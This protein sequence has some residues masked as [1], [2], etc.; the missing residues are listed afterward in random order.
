MPIAQ[1]TDTFITVA[2]SATT[3]IHSLAELVDRAR[4]QP[5]KLNYNAGAGALPYVFAGFL[6]KLDLSMILVSYRD[7]ALPVQDLGEGR[8][9]IMMAPITMMQA[10]ANAGKVRLIALTN[11]R[12]SPTADMTPTAREAGYPEIGFEGLAGFFGPR[13]LSTELRDRISADVRAVATLP[14]LADRLASVGQV[15]H[16]STPAEFAAAVEEQRAQMETIVKLV[17]NKL[18]Q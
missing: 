2:A 12:R 4:S 17:G 16:G 11:Q 5:G 8:I 13:G 9:Q 18:A 1:S 6:K 3:N 7:T 10:Q 14:A 15:A